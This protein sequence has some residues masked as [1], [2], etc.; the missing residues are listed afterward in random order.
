MKNMIWLALLLPTFALSAD[1]ADIAKISASVETCRNP[2]GLG[3]T[4][5]RVMLDNESRLTV[6]ES[7]PAP[8]NTAIDAV[9]DARLDDL[10]ATGSGGGI[11]P[12]PYECTLGQWQLHPDGSNLYPDGKFVHYYLGAGKQFAPISNVRIFL[13]QRGRIGIWTTTTTDTVQFINVTGPFPSAITA[14]N[15]LYGLI[16]AGRL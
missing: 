3:C 10:E 1:P 2:S 16:E 4:K 9:Q 11:G 7:T 12:V 14:E 15:C 5:G 6:I 13:A 8:D